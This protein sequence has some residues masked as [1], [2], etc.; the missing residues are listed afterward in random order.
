MLA[1]LFLS[2]RNPTDICLL[3]VS[4]TRTLT[5]CEIFS[6]LTIKTQE[7]FLVSLLLTLNRFYTLFFII[8]TI[9][10]LPIAAVMNI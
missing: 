5:L 4:S 9:T 3:K 7:S 8:I 2:S 1:G 10:I 6:N